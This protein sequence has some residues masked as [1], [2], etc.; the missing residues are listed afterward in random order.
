MKAIIV[1]YSLTSNTEF[2]AKELSNKLDCDILPLEV[3]NPYPD[4]GFKKFYWG[5]KSAVM[6]ESPELKK[7]TF[8]KDDYDVIILGTPVWAGTFTPHLRTFVKENDLSDKNVAIYA[9]SSGGKAINAINRLK[10]EIGINSDILSLEL[11]DPK[12]KYNDVVE[13]QINDF[14]EEIRKVFN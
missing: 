10:N 7:Y 11:V 4:K 5:G 3:L 14:S 9:C 12:N 2:V 8:N 13:N 1:Y 6:K